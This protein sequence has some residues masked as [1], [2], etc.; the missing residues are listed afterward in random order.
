MSWRIG[1]DGKVVKVL[2]ASSSLGSKTVEGCMKRAIQR[3]RF[4]KPEGG[5][6][7]I[8]FPFVFSAGL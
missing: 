8:R 6:C 7:Q 1:L 3:W 5:M 4:P 2:V